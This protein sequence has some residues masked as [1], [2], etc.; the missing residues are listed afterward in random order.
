[1]KHTLFFRLLIILCGIACGFGFQFFYVEQRIDGLWN[2]RLLTALLLGVLLFYPVAFSSAALMKFLTGDRTE[3]FE[4]K[5]ALTFLPLFM[6]FLLPLQKRF[7][8]GPILVQD[9]IVAVSL[10]VVC[11]CIF[12]VDARKNPK[13]SHAAGGNF[14]RSGLTISAVALLLAVPVF[15]FHQISVTF[16]D[17]FGA[18]SVENPETYS[19]W[20]EGVVR[21]TFPYSKKITFRREAPY[22]N[23]RAIVGFRIVK[24]Q[25][26]NVGSRYRWPQNCEL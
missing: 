13:T 26:K 3:S 8:E 18:G 5:D 17:F 6:L 22:E 21:E 1:M 7:W 4:R 9:I 25:M 12:L 23:S 15:W 2:C 24:A 10:I 11:K 19:R 20:H 16:P 14:S